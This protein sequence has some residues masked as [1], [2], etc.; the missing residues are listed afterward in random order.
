[1]ERNEPNLSLN[2]HTVVYSMSILHL[3]FI[4]PEDIILRELILSAV[5][6]IIYVGDQQINITEPI[7]HRSISETIASFES[8]IQTSSDCFTL[9]RIVDNLRHIRD[10]LD[11][12]QLGVLI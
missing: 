9:D 10:L 8:A 2:I 6:D 5:N 11:Q 3:Y 4:N 12:M 1:M 7:D